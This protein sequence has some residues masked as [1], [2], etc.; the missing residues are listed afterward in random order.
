MRVKQIFF[1]I[2]IFCIKKIR[3]GKIV[4]KY[5]HIIK[6]LVKSIGL[7]ENFH[8]LKE[9]NY[10]F[11]PLLH[12]LLETFL[13]AKQETSYAKEINEICIALPDATKFKSTLDLLPAIF[14]PLIDSMGQY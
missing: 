5:F 7:Y 3:S 6:Q 2:L 12:G 4:P 8:E 14:D 9:L 11:K 1:N 10:E 13:Q